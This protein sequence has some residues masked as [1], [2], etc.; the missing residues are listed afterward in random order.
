MQYR[1]TKLITS[2]CITYP[3]RVGPIADT[4]SLG[5]SSSIYELNTFLYHPPPP[6]HTNEY[7]NSALKIGSRL[8]FA[9]WDQEV[10]KQCSATNRRY[11]LFLPRL[12]AGGTLDSGAPSY[13]HPHYH[14]QSKALCALISSS[15]SS[16]PLSL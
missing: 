10:Q 3:T 4:H 14:Y 12:T 9:V 8:D 16:L 7:G 6:T 15:P 13:C 1:P 11:R 5:S 2:W